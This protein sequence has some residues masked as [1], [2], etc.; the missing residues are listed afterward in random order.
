MPFMLS[1]LRIL[2]ALCIVAQLPFARAAD[3]VVVSLPG[4]A[5]VTAEDLAAEA[6]R[7]PPQAQTQV[8]SGSSEVARFAQNLIVRRELA[9]RAEVDRLP[10]DPKVAAALRSARERVLAEA[11][12]ERAA[13]AAPD[14]ATLEQLARNQ[15][16]AAPQKFDRPEQVRVRHILISAKTCDAEAKARELLAKARQPGAD[17]AALAKENSDD[18]GS[19]ERGG[20]LGL[21]SRG[22]M[23]PAFE[24]AAFALQQPGDLSDV[25]KT[26]FGFHVIRLEEHKP[27]ERKPFEAVRGELVKTVAESE[28]R[29]RRQRVVDEITANIRFDSEAVDAL[30]ASQAKAARPK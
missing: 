22:R 12:L 8:L 25:V 23:A 27:A 5:V 29:A 9:R 3:A 7:L 14:R 1:M 2:V 24:S 15:Y 18:P 11:A 30:V 4:G 26:E 17:F 21:F 6:L 28:S 19:A 10:D 13:G 16:D 20:D